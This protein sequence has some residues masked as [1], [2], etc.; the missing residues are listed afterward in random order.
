MSNQINTPKFDVVVIGAG[1]KG[2]TCAYYL[3]KIGLEVLVL[4]EYS[5][6]GGMTITEEIAPGFISDIHAYGHQMANFYPVPKN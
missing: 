1:H 3:A 2:L 5:S 6:V 4:E